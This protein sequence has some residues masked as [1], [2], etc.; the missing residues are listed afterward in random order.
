MKRPLFLV[1]AATTAMVMASASAGS[2]R[3]VALELQF[4]DHLDAGMPEQ[5]VFVERSPGSDE[6]V[7]VTKETADMDAPLFLSTISQPHDPF[8]ATAV[9]P[10]PK[11]AALGLTLGTWLGASGSGRYVCEAGEGHID[12]TFEG[13]VPDGVYTLWHFFMTPTPTEPFIGTFDLPVGALDGSQSVFTADAYGNA[14]YKR[15]L[16]S[17]LQL[18]GSQLASGLAVNWHSDG[19]TYGPLPGDFGLNAHIQLFTVLPVPGES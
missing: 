7:R 16:A 14:V 6:V 11:G 8:D 5:D 1:S 9:G 18:T 12:V 17:C 2:A 3:D 15:T 10:F 19:K 4:F 13:L